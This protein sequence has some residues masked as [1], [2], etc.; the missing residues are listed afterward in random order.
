MLLQ[1]SVTRVL[2]DGTMMSRARAAATDST[3][4]LRT[5]GLSYPRYRDFSHATTV[6]A[7]CEVEDFCYIEA[8]RIDTY[9]NT[10]TVWSALSPPKQIDKYNISSDAISKSFETSSDLETST[11]DQVA[12]LLENHVHFLAYQGNLDLACNTAGNL[13]WANSLVWKGQPEFASKALRPWKHGNKVVGT[14][15]EVWIQA[16]DDADIESRFAIVTV[17]DAGHFVS[18]FYIY[19]WWNDADFSPHSFPKIAPMWLLI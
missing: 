7:P 9:L 2:L 19:K 3:V 17:D 15:K 12:Y 16:S 10:P 6:T 8:T 5:T 18:G 14:M 11:D 4:S 1:M 13:R